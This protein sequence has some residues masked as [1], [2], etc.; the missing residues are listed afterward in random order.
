LCVED[1]NLC[2]ELSA[3]EEEDVGHKVHTFLLIV[4]VIIIIIL[5]HIIIMIIVT[6]VVLDSS[7]MFVCMVEVSYFSM[8]VFTV[9]MWLVCYSISE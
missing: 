7:N 6:I 4:V 5:I 8:Y 9:V 1:E 2:S 3:S